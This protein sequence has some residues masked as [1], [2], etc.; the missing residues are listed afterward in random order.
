MNWFNNMTLKGK[1][2]TG[3]IV[4]AIIGA[5]I[6]GVGIFNIKKIDAAATKMYEK[7]AVPLS[8]LSDIS[9]NFQRIRI[10]L[11]ELAEDTNAQ[12]RQ[13]NLETI[14]KL[15]KET[16][17]ISEKFE[18]TI[19]TDDGR[20]MFADFKETR[21]AYGKVIDRT[22]SLASANKN[23][24][25]VSLL[26]GEGKKAAFAEQELL[27]KLQDSK[28]K[29]AKMT[30][31]ENTAAANQ[32][33]TMMIIFI[34]LGAIF[35]I[36]LGMFIAKIVGRQLG[37]DPKL[38][39]ELANYVA[40]GELS[41]EIALAS[42]DTTSVMA[43]M[44]KM[45]DVINAMTAETDKLVTATIAGQLAT[46]GDVAKFAGGWGKLI[47]GVNNLCD[48]FVGP[49]NVTAEY[50]DRI[51]KGDIPPKITDSYN[52]DFN[53]IKNN[54]NACI[55]TM[56]G[57]LEET[58]K[59]VKATVAGQLATRGDTTKF[60]GGWSTL[61]KGVNELCDAFVGPINVTAEYVDRI[62]KGDIPPKITDS[63]NGDG[64]PRF[65]RCDEHSFK[66]KN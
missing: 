35:G 37:A 33:T 30:S 24:E 28:T 58:D 6:G 48:A 5:V 50:V 7:I 63:Y 59:L 10:N 65:T 51:S 13:K 31:D 4:V 45:L 29:Q 34:I 52:G 18:K 61:V 32:A 39:G 25:A 20:K 27:D 21:V 12:E 11:R 40:A 56:S 19:L 60:T 62:S 36:G 47:G 42:G 26:D 54:L 46:R 9:T 55:D 23:A 2:L 64:E 17:E 8:E 1:L 14:N 44:K 43:A 53:E 41:R 57:L 22:I 49:I 38:V 16:G 66:S 3:F 15:R